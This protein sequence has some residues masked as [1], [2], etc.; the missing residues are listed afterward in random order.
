MKRLTKEWVRKADADYLAATT[1]GPAQALLRDQV[2]FH[3]QQ[4]AEKYLKGLMQELGLAVPRTHL[5]LTL[6]ASLLSHHNTLRSLRRGLDFLTRY[7]VDTRYPGH[8]ASKR[9]TL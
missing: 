7:A 2:C 3:C 4:C 9:Q 1:L 8:N 6:L 5:L